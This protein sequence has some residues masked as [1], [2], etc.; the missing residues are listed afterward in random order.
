MAG[1]KFCF[2]YRNSQRVY[3]PVTPPKLEVQKPGDNSTL[4]IVNLGDV[5]ILKTPGLKTIS[6]ESFIPTQ[7]TGSYIEP[8]VQVFTSEFYKNFFE[9]IM[10]QKEPINFVVT[11]LNVA[12]QMSL[13][14]FDYWWDGG[15]P[16]MHF[17]I[18]LKEFRQSTIKVSNIG[19]NVS[20]NPF[21]N[22]TQRLNTGKYPTIGSKVLVNGVLHRD[23]YGAGP[24]VTEKNAIRLISHT[25]TGRTH[26]FHVT[27]LNGGWRGWVTK[28]SL[29]VI[30]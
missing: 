13:E 28:D 19:S 21:Q 1:I 16:D 23:S 6:F 14:D 3:L 11:E 8:D 27:T 4:N 26:G 24:G 12:M 30:E 9:A 29:E 18:K 20:A 5:S 2:E 15:D 17:K 22:N 7:N 10:A 25:K